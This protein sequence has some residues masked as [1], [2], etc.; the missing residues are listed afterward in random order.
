MARKTGLA[1]LLAVFP[2]LAF[3]VPA[4][5][6]TSDLC[7]QLEAQRGQGSLGGGAHL[8][9]YDIAIAEQRQQLLLA[10]DRTAE[11]G[12][13]FSM[14]GAAITY[15][16]K[17]NAKIDEMEANLDRLLRH[18]DKSSVAAADADDRL[19][20]LLA[21]NGCNTGGT[22]GIDANADLIEEIFGP[23]N[24]DEVAM[25]KAGAGSSAQK[26]EESVEAVGNPAPAQKASTLSPSIV[27]PETRTPPKPVAPQIAVSSS[28]TPHDE[29][30]PH[31]P[32]PDRKVRVVGPRF[33]PDPEA[34]IDLQAPARRQAR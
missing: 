23:G 13:G 33:L 28:E 11:A 5:S 32:D 29:A 22:T 7:R 1:A 31:Q 20:S 30:M 17:L 15:C 18:S 12:C 27:A 24:Q 2:A 3:F 26:D 6:A 4:A 34:A 25:P 21:A 8:D 16:A 10:R 14:V 9:R 19:L